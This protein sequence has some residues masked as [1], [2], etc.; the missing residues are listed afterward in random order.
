M[1]SFLVLVV[2]E[3]VSLDDS[4]VD[5]N[6]LSFSERIMHVMLSQPVPSPS[7]EGARQCSNI[8]TQ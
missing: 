5:G 2:V 8:C 3:V 7:K 6:F 1:V 4:G